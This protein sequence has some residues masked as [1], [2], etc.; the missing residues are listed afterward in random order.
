MTVWNL[1]HWLAIRWFGGL[2]LPFL[3]L[4]NGF[5]T[6]DV[7]LST[8]MSTAARV[9]PCLLPALPDWFVCPGDIQKVSFS[10]LL[11]F[12]LDHLDC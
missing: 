5:Y 10:I 2:L 12:T 1:V 11:R 3:G 9:Y 8:A 4:R 6:D 7:F